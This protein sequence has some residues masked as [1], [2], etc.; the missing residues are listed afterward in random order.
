MM[1]GKNEYMGQKDRHSFAVASPKKLLSVT[2]DLK[3]GKHE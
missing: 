1:L 2:V 3:N